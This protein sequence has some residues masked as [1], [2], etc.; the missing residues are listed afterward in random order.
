MYCTVRH[1]EPDLIIPLRIS[2]SPSHGR[3]NPPDDITHRVVCGEGAA[4]R[5]QTTACRFCFLREPTCCPLARRPGPPSLQS[6]A[7]NMAQLVGWGAVVL[8]SNTPTASPAPPKPLESS[9]S[10]L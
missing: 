10:T 2:Y 6:L 7:W 1:A 4:C 3:I 5:P 9:V 8:K